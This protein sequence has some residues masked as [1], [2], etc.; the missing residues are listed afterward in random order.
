MQRNALVVVALAS[1]AACTTPPTFGERLETEAGEVRRLGEAWNRGAEL[2][3][4]GERVIADGERLISRGEE[5][6]AEGRALVREGERL[7]RQSERD[8]RM[9]PSDGADG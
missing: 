7:M 5:R 8:Y 2:V 3:E 6:V 9:R 4:R 1:L